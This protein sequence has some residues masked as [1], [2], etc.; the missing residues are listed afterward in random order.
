MILTYVIPPAIFVVGAISLNFL[1][2][3]IGGVAWA[4]MILCYAPTLRLYTRRPLEALLLP[5]AALMYTL[6]TIDSAQRFWRHKDP[7]WKGRAN[8]IGGARNP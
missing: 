7:T 2:I 5:I 3:A 6:M 1:L 4:I 8:Q